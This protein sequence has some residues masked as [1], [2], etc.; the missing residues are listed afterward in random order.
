ML[1]VVII[2]YRR[3]EDVIECIE[4]VKKY[5]TIDHEVIVICNDGHDYEPMESVRFV[6]PGHNLGVAGGRNLGASLAEGE[7]LFFIDDDA[8]VYT[9]NIQLSSFPRNTGIVSVISRD[10]YTCELR[11]LENPRVNGTYS[12]KYVGVGHLVR[13]EVFEDCGGYDVISN[14]GMEEYN[15]QY[16]AYNKGW[17]ISNSSIVVL[18]KKSL[19]GR[20]HELELKERLAITKIK[21][22]EGVVPLEVYWSHLFFWTFNI[23]FCHRRFILSEVS[24]IPKKKIRIDRFKFYRAVIKTRANVFY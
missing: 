9:F 24:I 15:L 5:L 12:S 1:S 17:L 22:V 6:Q 19:E 4:S 7:W 20:S 13:K 14:Y 2:S 16:K 21:L 8:V 10:Y 3:H 18:H 23:L 11:N